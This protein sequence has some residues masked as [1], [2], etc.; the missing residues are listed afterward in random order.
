MKDTNKTWAIINEFL[1]GKN[2][3]PRSAEVDRLIKKVCGENIQ[4][5]SQSDIVN[6]FN[7]FFVN[8]GLNLAD[9]LPN[10]DIAYGDWGGGGGNKEQSL[11]WK[12]ITAVEALLLDTKN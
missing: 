1:A 5:T 3:S 10:K 9:E 7:D 11:F 8:I 12:P 4:L 6:E 2:R